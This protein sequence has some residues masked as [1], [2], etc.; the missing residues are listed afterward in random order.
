MFRRENLFVSDH[1]ESPVRLDY[2]RDKTLLMVIN[3][4]CSTTY[5]EGNFFSNPDSVR[6]TR[7]ITEETEQSVT[8]NCVG[9][10][11]A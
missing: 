5:L 1:Q 2:I 7:G 8:S 10:G 11:D 3:G 6:V 9:A 4:P